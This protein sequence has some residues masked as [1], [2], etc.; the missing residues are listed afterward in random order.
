VEKAVIAALRPCEDNRIRK[1][2][3]CGLNKDL[4]PRLE[5]HLG[6]G[7]AP[8]CVDVRG[9]VVAAVDAVGIVAAAAAAA[10]VDDDDDGVAPHSVRLAQKHVPCS[11]PA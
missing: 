10:A 6:V 2:E 8:E 11:R 1:T 7:H 4:R 3:S 5:L 9:I